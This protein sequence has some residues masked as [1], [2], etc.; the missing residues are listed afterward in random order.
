MM[1]I[2]DIITA[3]VKRVKMNS[4]LKYFNYKEITMQYGQFTVLI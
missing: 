4:E 2:S 1:E 3:I